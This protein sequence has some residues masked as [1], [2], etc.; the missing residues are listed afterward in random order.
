[1]SN[2]VSV[3][4][5]VPLEN[6][7]QEITYDGMELLQQ[8]LTMSE[9]LAKLA[10]RID[11][12]GKD[13][14][15]GAGSSSA[16]A[17]STNE[18]GDVKEEDTV[19]GEGGPDSNF[20]TSQ[21]W[22]WESVRNKIRS[23]L[24]E[25]SV[26]GDILTIA[27][28]KQ[29]MVLD[30]VQAEPS[31]TKPPAVL[32]YKKKALGAASQVLLGG[33]ERLR[34]SM[35]E[36]KSR[37]SLATLDFHIELLRLRQNW[38]LRKVGNAILGDLSYRTAGSRFPQGGIFEV[39]KAE[40]DTEEGMADAL[41]TSS[42]SQPPPPKPCSA[43]RVTVPNELQGIAYIHVHVQKDQDTLSF[44]NIGLPA[45]APLDA[46]WQQRLEAAQ[47]VLF[48]KEL[49]SVL[50]REAVAL[51]SMPIPPLVVG[52]QIT[53]TLFPGILLIIGLCHSITGKTQ[54]PPAVSSKLDHNHVLEHSLHQLL[55]EVHRTN[56]HIPLPHPATAPI[57]ISRKRRLGGPCAYDRQTLLNMTKKEGIL[58]EII[59]QSQHVILRLRAMYFLDTLA[60]EIKDPLLVAHWASINAVTHSCVR[61]TL[62][63]SGYDMCA[64]TQLVI[65]I[66][67]KSLKAILKDG[68]AINLSYEPQELKDLLLCQIA[69]HQIMAL[70]S[71]S[72][73]LGWT[74]LSSC[75]HL[76]VGNCESTGNAAGCM[77]TSPNGKRILAV[78]SSPQAF[79][80]A[81]SI[82]VFIGYPP[83]AKYTT[84][85]NN[86]NP[87]PMEV[88]DTSA[89]TLG[90]EGMDLAAGVRYKSVRLDK[91]EGKNFLNKMEMLMAVLADV[92]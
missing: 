59:K 5:E 21:S 69:I 31:D 53:A 63:S 36:A 16:A 61:I 6:L 86:N 2:S 70:Q 62:V 89:A 84:Q 74:V 10:Q 9:S 32:M 28:K 52:N 8:P 54:S 15:G 23:A 42:Q 33:C 57:G 3:S 55:R 48:C 66:K 87:I 25:L 12:C 4:V 56:S 85:Q 30:P 79:M 22:P 43:L 35:N 29:Y 71:L 26:L 67:E 91:L 39:T 65:H 11:F 24:T 73:C 40:D 14:E 50:A 37:P 82:Q 38:R 68:K 41:S 45:P 81:A 34:A 78:R 47:N 20:K 80:S 7:V 60:K 19:N 18:N 92:S 1:M 51:H 75:S 13:E 17:G 76:G 44:A 77:L 49:F 83:N 58:E 88:D 64:R 90:F 27:Q 46:H 72:K